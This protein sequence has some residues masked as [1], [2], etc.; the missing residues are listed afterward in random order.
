MVVMHPDHVVGPQQFLEM[1]R[2]ILVDANVA[3]EVAAREF[4]K[5]E[6]VMQNGPQHPV[7]E[8]VVE[9]LIIVL[10]EIDGGVGCVVLSHRADGP[11]YVLRNAA[12]PTEPQTAVSFK[13][14]PD[15]NFKS[16]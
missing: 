5:I 1:A 9:F 8:A 13:R 14:R 11:R 12:T 15:R 7:C 2:E 10:A 4:G 3:T 6:S 16:A